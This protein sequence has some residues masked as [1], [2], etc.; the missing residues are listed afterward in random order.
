MQAGSELSEGLGASAY[1]LKEECYALVNGYLWNDT[2]FVTC[3]D[4]R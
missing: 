3:L 1:L 2:G 4:I